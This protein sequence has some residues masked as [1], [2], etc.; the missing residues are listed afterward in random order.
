M[1]GWQDCRGGGNLTVQRILILG[2]LTASCDIGRQSYIKVA[3][4]EFLAVFYILQV[5]EI[6]KILI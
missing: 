6:L 4:K 2:F 1:L 3:I 5:L